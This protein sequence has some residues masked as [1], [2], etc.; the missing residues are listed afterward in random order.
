[1][2]NGVCCVKSPQFVCKVQA[3]PQHKARVNL[4]RNKKNTSKEFF[5]TVYFKVTKKQWKN[6]LL[7][8]QGLTS[9]LHIPNLREIYFFT[10]PPQSTT[11]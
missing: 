8:L 6:N 2:M 5:H 7:H 1:M 11:L 10:M 9:Q 3:K 4:F